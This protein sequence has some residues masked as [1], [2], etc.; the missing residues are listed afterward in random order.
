MSPAGISLLMLTAFGGF[1]YLAWRKLAIVVALKP[2]VR[3]NDPRARLK[4]LLENGFLQ[5]RM[6]RGE[7]KPGIMHAVIFAGFLALLARKLQLIVVGYDES[8]VYPGALGVAFTFGKDWSKSRCWLQSAMRS[9]AA[10]CKSR[11]GSSPIG[12]RLSSSR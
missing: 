11:H 6:I 1:F 7:R 10:S 4:E 9:S 8:F 5:A 3:W 12:R 2:E